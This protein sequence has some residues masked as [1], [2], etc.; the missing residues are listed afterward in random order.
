MHV[1]A[2]ITTKLHAL[3]DSKNV[4]F[5]NAVMNAALFLDPRFKIQLQN[6]SEKVE[7]GISL[8][9]NIWQ[10]IN[11]SDKTENINNSTNWNISFEFDEQAELNKLLMRNDAVI[12]TI[13]LDVDINLLLNL[14]NPD[15]MPTQTSILQFWENSKHKHPEL[16]KLAMVIYS[17]PPTEV[18]IEGDFSILNH[19]FSNRRCAI[20]GSR[21]EDILLINIDS[22]VFFVVKAEELNDELIKFSTHII[23][24]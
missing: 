24:E 6:D 3:D 19:V 11:L 16:Y 15:L 12:E 8:L 9:V 1:R 7:S 13:N 23:E 21:L 14:F 22:D 4:N 20:Q 5:G 10:R 18:Q 17:I 2:K